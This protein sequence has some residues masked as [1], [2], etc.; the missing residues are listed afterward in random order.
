MTK[1]L[2]VGIV[3]CGNVGTRLHLP[4][5]LARPDLAQVVGLADPT[6]SVLEAARIAAGLPAGEV[7]RE[8]AELI[9]RSDVDA[10]DVCTPQHLRR[11]ILLDAIRAGKHILC[12]NPLAAVPA[13][14]AATSRG[15]RG[16]AT[17]APPRGTRAPTGPAEARRSLRQRQS[18]YTGTAG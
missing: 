6:E 15:A 13:D 5:W 3:G 12:E 17:P 4:S 1:R 8:P 7:H 14:A 2:R 11:D 18:L 9:A 16:G 10:V